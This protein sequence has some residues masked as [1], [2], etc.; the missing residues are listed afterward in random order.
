VSG[1]LKKLDNVIMAPFSRS[2]DG[3]GAETLKVNVGI[4]G[5]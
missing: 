3:I 2:L 1:V 4:S 5:K